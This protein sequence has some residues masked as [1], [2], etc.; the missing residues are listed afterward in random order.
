MTLNCITSLYSRLRKRYYNYRYFSDGNFIE[1]K[2]SGFYWR[3]D[4]RS[5]IGESIINQGIWEENTTKLIKETVK[6]GMHIL[7]IGANVGYYTLIL[8]K[9]VGPKG[10]VWAFEPVKRFRDQL[11]WHIEKNNFSDI[12]TVLP[13]GLSDTTIDI[14]ISIDDSTATLHWPK[15]KPA[16]EKEII[17]LKKLDDIVDD[18]KIKNID[19]IKIDI[20]GNE[21]K[22]FRGAATFFKNCHPPIAMEFAQ[23]CLHVAGSDVRELAK[24]L[25]EYGYILCNEKSREPFPTDFDFLI[26]C[27][28]FDHSGNAFAVFKKSK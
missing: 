25:N 10:K 17:S 24:I 14:P 19:F 1:I 9:S 7:D 16:V 21:P 20:D 28:N 23:L 4:P 2:K 26:E 8:A 3:L 15:S 18:L 12:V 13:Y 5:C 27:G 22:F 11:L 6:P